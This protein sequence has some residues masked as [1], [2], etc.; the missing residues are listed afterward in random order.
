[1]SRKSRVCIVILAAGE[2]RRLGQPK[3]LLPYQGTTI[4]S[5]IVKVAL[6]SIA[7]QTI[8]ITGAHAEPIHKELESLDVT[9]VENRLWKEGMSTSIRRGIEVIEHSD[10]PSSAVLLMTC[11][12][13]R[14]STTLINTIIDKF[15]NQDNRIV[16][17]EYEETIG[18]PAM[19][20][21]SYFTE[22]KSLNG[23]RGAKEITMNYRD[24]LLTVPFPDG[25]LDIDITDD[26]K[27]LRHPHN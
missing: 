14:V 25:G 1:M 24:Y 21:S 11:D 27:Q 9:I 2:S 19:F 23:D 18:V 12:Q 6:A 3:Q 16:A 26:I 8:V 5:H 17:C 20:C 15:D 13:P 4:I 7:N 22:L 10:F